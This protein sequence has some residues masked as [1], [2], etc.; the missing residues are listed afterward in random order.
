MKK[1]Y[2]TE[3]VVVQ[4]NFEPHYEKSSNVPERE[5]VTLIP[6]TYHRQVDE[7]TDYLVFSGDELET[8]QAN[9]YPTIQRI[10]DTFAAFRN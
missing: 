2:G 4:P 6:G 10:R 8:S 9:A 5:Q 1:R 7:N 3:V